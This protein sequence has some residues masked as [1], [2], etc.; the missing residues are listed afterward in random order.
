MKNKKCGNWKE[1]K[2]YDIIP[3][4]TVIDRWDFELDIWA[5]MFNV[6]FVP[7]KTD[8]NNPGNR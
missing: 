6:T 1:K 2:Y 7:T 3:F 5:R 4:F 8:R